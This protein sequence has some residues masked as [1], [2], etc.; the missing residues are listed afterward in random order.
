[1]SKGGWGV[2]ETRFLVLFTHWSGNHFHQ[3]QTHFPVLLYLLKLETSY[4]RSEIF[5]LIA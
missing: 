2:G 5:K 4:I 3:Y 1:M